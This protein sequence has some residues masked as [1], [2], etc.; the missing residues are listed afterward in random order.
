MATLQAENITLQDQFSLFEA[1]I[2]QSNQTLK[3]ANE[4]IQKLEKE[5]EE[6]KQ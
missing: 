5:L 6:S 1:K 2:D 4:K 3:Q